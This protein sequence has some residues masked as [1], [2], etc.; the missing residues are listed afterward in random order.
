ME[1]DALEALAE[2]QTIVDAG[3]KPQIQWS[4][5]HG[6]VVTDLLAGPAPWER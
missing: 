6:W 4:P 1:A 5:H 3:G 2:Y